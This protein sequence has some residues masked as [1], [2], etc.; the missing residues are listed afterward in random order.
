MSQPGQLAR[1]F[2]AS[3][4][5]AI[6]NTLNRL[7]GFLLLPLYTRYL[8]VSEYGTLEFI[9]A[10]SS[11]VG[12]ILSVG[13][14]SATLRFYFDYEDQ[15]DRNAVISTSFWASLI[16]SAA[17]SVAVWLGLAFFHDHVFPPGTPTLA[18]PLMLAAI[19]LELSTEVCLAYVRAR[20]MPRFFVAMSLAK[21]VI[22]CGAN[23]Y[24][25]RVADAGILGVLTGNLLAIGAG[26]LVLAVYCVKS[27]GSRL[28]MAKLMPVLRYCA[29][30]LGTT[31]VGIVA[32]NFDRFLINGV[33]SVQALGIYAL[34]LKFSRI[35]GDFVG[36]PFNLA[37][38]AYRYTIMTLPNAGA[39]QARIVRYLSC[40]LALLGLALCYY[41]I[42]L[43][44]VMTT[45][46]YWPAADLMPLLALA[47]IM[48]VIAVPLQ[49]GILYKKR[50]QELLYITIAAAA[51]G[52]PLAW[53]GARYFGLHGVCFAMAVT[54]VLTVLLTGWYGHRHFP[55]RYE[56]GK[57]AAL[58][59]LWAGFVYLPTALPPLSPLAGMLAKTGLLI[60]FSILLV[61]LRIVDAAELKEAAASI[62]R[63]PN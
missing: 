23:I 48:G 55:V 31:L 18:V 20:E 19:C 30:Y 16:I 56:A 53:G 50:T 8:T 38:G 45:P 4:I 47:S 46:E 29:P 12:G 33:L 13:I 27:C 22:Q 41:L 11:I 21:L 10:V 39:L 17:G 36:V 24:L 43:L 62:R 6:G 58:A 35:L 61:A 59:A 15:R 14:A 1:L 3:G 44:R 32:G 49:T 60:V 51:C 7:G 2:R 52:L 57:L 42:D 40:L 63:K 25:V 34:A 28:E 5:Y 37:F 54:A 26:W 9:Y